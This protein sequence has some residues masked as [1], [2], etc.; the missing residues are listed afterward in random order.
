MEEKHLFMYMYLNNIYF[1]PERAKMESLKKGYL[2][3]DLKRN[4]ST[5]QWESRSF[6]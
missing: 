5:M 4:I 1:F 6:E 2:E 3:W